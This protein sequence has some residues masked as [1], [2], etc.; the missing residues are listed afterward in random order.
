MG[1]TFD[2]LSFN[3]TYISKSEFSLDLSNRAFR[4]GDGLFESMHANG[5]EVQF[6]DAHY[7]RILKGAQVLK[8]DLPD[9]FS[10]QYL[11]NHISG[12][13][14]RC[15]LYQGA[16]VKLSIF[17]SSPG[18]YIPKQ[19][20]V[21]VLIEASYL[22]KGPYELNN[23]GLVIDVFSEMPKPESPFSAFKSMN[24]LPYVLAGVEVSKRSIDDIL[25]LSPSGHIVEATSS[26]FF[27]L[28]GSNLYSPSNEL[29]CVEGVMKKQVLT[30]AQEH[31]FSIFKDAYLMPDDLL[32]M[33]ELF[34][35]NA[36]SGIKWIVAYKNK[37][38]LKRQAA[39]LVS[40]LNQ[41]ALK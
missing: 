18:L 34:L 29:G 3:Q 41:K 27:A 36:V 10:V 40:A 22:S 2:I 14:Q 19:N 37:R 7:Q 25:L 1:N 24:A 33:D 5:G 31:G 4:Y 38:Y 39:R 9:Y 11:Q 15:R 20:S 16:R 28:S 21:D 32:K 23:K 13:L 6:L 30:L 17:R 12:L 8:F 26:N 35:T